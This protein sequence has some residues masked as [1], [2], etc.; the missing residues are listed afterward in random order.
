LLAI[1]GNDQTV[2][3]WDVEGHTVK[4][5]AL[6]HPAVVSAVTFS[7]DG[8]T[9]LT[10]TEDGGVY[11]W[12][13]ASG[14]SLGPLPSYPYRGVVTAVAFHPDG[15]SF[16]VATGQGIVQI[17][18]FDARRPRGAPLPHRAG[19]RAVAFS[20]DGKVLAT[21]S[22]DS[23]SWLWD[24]ATS[25]PLC[26]PLQHHDQ[27]LTVAFSADGK[28]LLT[29]SSD[30]AVRLS[31]VATGLRIGPA[32]KHSGP[33]WAAFLPSPPPGSAEGQRV[34]ATVPQIASLADDGYLRLWDLPIARTGSTQEI[35]RA[36]EELTGKRLGDKGMLRDVES[37]A[38]GG[39]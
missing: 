19:V 34:G 8:Q 26:T 15:K 5:P 22:Y 4:G 31:D 9:L 28:T 14:N 17:W 37:P 27:V 1:S 10:G 18:D 38:S 21:G 23:T 7:P 20:P 39:K 32:L 33:V 2:Q 13:V 36:I 16:V 24:V 12:D 3:L 35:K 25:Q 11:L 30:H 6:K 29:G